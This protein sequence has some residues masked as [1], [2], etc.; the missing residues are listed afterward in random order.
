MK[1]ESV[2]QDTRSA[3]DSADL[4]MLELTV[5]HVLAELMRAEHYPLEPGVTEILRPRIA[6]AVFECA[7]RGCRDPEDLKQVVLEHFWNPDNDRF[8]AS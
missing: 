4:R 7:D 2:P 8:L 3:Y 5:D 1:I 6:K